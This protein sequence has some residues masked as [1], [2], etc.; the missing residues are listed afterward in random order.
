MCPVGKKKSVSQDVIS[1]AA[2]L[3][4]MRAEGPP[5]E[6]T[7]K[8]GSNYAITLMTFKLLVVCWGCMWLDKIGG[9]PSEGKKIT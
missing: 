1:G 8:I 4:A 6:L 9:A 3:E 5:E 7:D 2:A